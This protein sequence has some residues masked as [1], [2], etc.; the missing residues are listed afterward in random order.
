MLNLSVQSAEGVRDGPDALSML[1][2]KAKVKKKRDLQE[3]ED[4]MKRAAEA[5]LDCFQQCPSIEAHT[6]RHTHMHTRMRALTQAHIH[7]LSH[8]TLPSSS[9]PPLPLTPHLLTLTHTHTTP[10]QVLVP[11]LLGVRGSNGRDW[12]AAIKQ[13][14]QVVV[15]V[16]VKPMLGKVGRSIKDILKQFSQGTVRVTLREASGSIKLVCFLC[17]FAT[18]GSMMHFVNILIMLC[19]SVGPF[20]C[21]TKYDGQRVQVHLKADGT[22]KLFSRNQEDK[23]G[24]HTHTHTHT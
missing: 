12:V 19:S 8:L 4:T 6:Q 22:F 10:L 16:P 5:T 13:Q 9:Y 21:E 7:M 14:R 11:M 1:Q 3:L 23:T 24:A 20:T 17:C 15:G 2:D 18:Y